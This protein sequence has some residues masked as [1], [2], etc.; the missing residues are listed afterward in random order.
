VNSVPDA[1]ASLTGFAPLLQ[2]P[3]RLQIMAVLVNVQEAEFARLKTVTGA[4]DSVVS[5][6]LSALAEAGLIALRKGA[7]DGRARTWVSVTRTGRTT[8]A[9]H[10]AALRRIVGD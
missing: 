9:D 1:E 6:H 8:F 3:A 7:M 10:V 2:A 4:S 5:K